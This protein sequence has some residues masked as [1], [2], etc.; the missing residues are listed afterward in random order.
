MKKSVHNEHHRDRVER[1]DPPRARH[2]HDACNN[3]DQ[4]TPG[5]ATRSGTAHRGWPAS[6]G[7]NIME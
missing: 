3:R 4:E 5:N 7:L 1:G 2:Q 6:V